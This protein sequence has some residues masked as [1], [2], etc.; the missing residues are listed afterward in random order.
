MMTRTG[1]VIFYGL[2]LDK[3]ENKFILVVVSNGHKGINVL[4]ASHDIYSET[5][6]YRSIAV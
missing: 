5:S 2:L 6:H 1:H 4:V 3:P